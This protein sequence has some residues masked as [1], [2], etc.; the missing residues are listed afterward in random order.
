[1]TVNI[2]LFDAVSA[3]FVKMQLQEQRKIIKKVE[4]ELE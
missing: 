4:T 2:M 3:N 1:M